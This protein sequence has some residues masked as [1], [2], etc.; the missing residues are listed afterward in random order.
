MLGSARAMKMQGGCLLLGNHKSALKCRSVGGCVSGN[1]CP[2][3]I[4][5]LGASHESS[6]G[7]IVQDWSNALKISTLNA[8]CAFQELER[9]KEKN[10]TRQCRHSDL[11]GN[12]LKTVM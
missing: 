10:S 6:G 9:K 11:K 2:W 4:A 1:L 12:R 8:A 7:C 5:S 3:P